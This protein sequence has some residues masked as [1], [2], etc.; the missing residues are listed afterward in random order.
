MRQRAQW[1]RDGGPRAL[2]ALRE[3]GRRPARSD[4][5]PPLRWE[6]AIWIWFERMAMGF[7]ACVDRW[8]WWQIAQREGWDAD[9]AFNLLSE[10]EVSLLPV[11]TKT[12]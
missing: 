11:E 7:P 9:L 8:S 6:R 10:I 12:P 3:L 4:Y 5:G 2:Q 1:V